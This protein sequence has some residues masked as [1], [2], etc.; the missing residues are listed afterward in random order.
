VRTAVVLALALVGLCGC[1]K[2]GGPSN[3]LVDRGRVVYQSNCI[4]CHNTDPKKPGTLG[5]E[6]WGSPLELVEARVMRAEYPPGYTPKRQTHQMVAI[7]QLKT[8]IPALHAY[9][10]AKD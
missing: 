4:A 3:A 5:P 9:L 6:I 2:S 7:P 8:D 10:N 1:T